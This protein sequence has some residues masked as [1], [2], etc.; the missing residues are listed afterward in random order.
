RF[1]TAIVAI[2]IGFAFEVPSALFADAASDTLAG[3]RVTVATEDADLTENG[4]RIKTDVQLGETFEVLKVDGDR[5]FVG[6]GWIA[7]SQVVPYDAAISYFTDQIRRAPTA[8]SYQ[9]RASAYGQ[10]NEFD[11]AIDDLNEAIR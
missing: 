8:E 5:L 6:R 2:A 4:K 10:R 1:G 3:K 11:K 9:H 7:R